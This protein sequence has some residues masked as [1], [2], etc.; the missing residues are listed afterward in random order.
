M[1]RMPT[2]ERKPQ[3]EKTLLHDFAHSGAVRLGIACL[4]ASTAIVSGGDTLAQ[5]TQQGALTQTA[6]QK[7]PPVKQIA[8]TES[9]I[10]G[11]IAASK[12]I[13]SITDSAPESIDRLNAET[14]ARLDAVARRNGVASY[15]E[16]LNVR[17]NVGLVFGGFDT[18]TRRYVGKEAAIKMRAARIRADKKMSVEEKKEAL[19]DLKDDLQLPLP[20]VEH[21][22]NIGLVIKYADKL[23]ATMR[24][25]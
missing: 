9:Q 25:D 19:Q 18:V 11:V 6:P 1:I 13:H 5:V 17:E 8:L 7:L 22:G 12:D 15:A 16:Y 23:N 3:I 21:K 24:D 2:I 10:K 14:I 4:V 20:L